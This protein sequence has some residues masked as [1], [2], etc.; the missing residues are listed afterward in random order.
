MFDKFNN[1]LLDDLLNFFEIL[2]LTMDMQQI[3]IPMLYISIL[4]MIYSMVS[5]FKLI[6]F[7]QLSRRESVQDNKHTHGKIQIIKY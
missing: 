7:P 3:K 1:P 5:S 6:I 2:R 4:N